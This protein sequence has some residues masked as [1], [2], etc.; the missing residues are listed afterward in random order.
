MVLTFTRPR[1]GGVNRVEESKLLVRLGHYRHI[2]PN[3]SPQLLLYIRI[4]ILFLA[5]ATIKLRTHPAAEII[6]EEHL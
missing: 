2:L 4:I 5:Q 1:G 6:L 3:T